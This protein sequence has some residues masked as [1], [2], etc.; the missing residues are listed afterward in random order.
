MSENKEK[1]Y[2][3]NFSEEEVKW[4]ITFIDAAIKFKGVL[5]AQPAFVLHKKLEEPIK[6]ERGQENINKAVD[7]TIKKKG[8]KSDVNSSKKC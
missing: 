6:V 8:K 1:T 4:L 5:W 2:N 7:Q 3:Y